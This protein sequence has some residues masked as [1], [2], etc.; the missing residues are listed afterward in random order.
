MPILADLPP[1]F[2]NQDVPVACVAMAAESFQIHPTILLAVLKQ[3]GGRIGTASKNRNGSKDLGP[4]QINT[5]WLKTLQRHGIAPVDVQFNG[6]RNMYIGSWILRQ[7]LDEFPDFWRGV[8]CYNSRTRNPVDK[9]AVYAAQVY[10]HYSKLSRY[11]YQWSW[12]QVVVVDQETGESV[13]I[14]NV[15][16]TEKMVAAN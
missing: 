1:A 13:R 7:C 10:D 9:N 6:C 16:G 11:E 8:G 3:E 15:D 5:G 4:A 14:L 12:D 2:V